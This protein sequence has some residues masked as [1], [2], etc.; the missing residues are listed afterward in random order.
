MIVQTFLSPTIISQD[1]E[2]LL[3]K[4]NV[5]Y[6]PEI[7]PVLIEE[8]SLALNCF[9]NID[10]KVRRDGGKV[11]YGWAILQGEFLIEA[12]RH[13][14]WETDSGDL[15]DITPREEAKFSTTMFVSDNDFIYE[16]QLVDNIRHNITTNPLVDDYVRV[17]ETLE[18]FYM[19]GTRVN[20]FMMEFPPE[21][22]PYIKKY[23]G[24]KGQLYLYL[25]NGGKPKDICNCP[26]GLSHKVRFAEC[27]G[28]VLK[29]EIVKD[30]ELIK[31]YQSKN[32]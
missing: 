32:S 7:I 12:E 14:V 18:M 5:E 27:H 19:L 17:C 25:L 4:M 2:K 21:L 10:E 8:Y 24:I 3:V 30:R 28:K 1:I 20:D 6:D 15:I 11:H 23:E 22:E 9:N 26:K 29:S 31:L 13:A 16:G